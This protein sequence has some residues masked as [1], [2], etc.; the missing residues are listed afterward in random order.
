MTG[1][2][3]FAYHSSKR[4]YSGNPHDEYAQWLETLYFHLCDKLYPLLEEAEKLGKKIGIK[5]MGDILYSDIFISDL[6][7]VD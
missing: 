7:F 2:E 4:N 1:K 3:L 6:I 5:E